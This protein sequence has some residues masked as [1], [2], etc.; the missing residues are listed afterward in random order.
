MG[1]VYAAD[2]L[3]LPRTVAIKVLRPAYRRNPEAVARLLAEAQAVNLI[4]HD[5]IVEIYDFVAD[6]SGPSYLVMELVAGE[7]LLDE[8]EREVC[9]PVRRVIDIGRQIADATRAVHDAGIVHRDLKPENVLLVAADE[10][11]VFVKLLDFGIAKVAEEGRAQSPL[12]ESLLPTTQHGMVVGTPD[13]MAPEQARGHAVDARADIFA[14]GVMLYEMLTGMRP[15]QGDSL[16]ELMTA[17]ECRTPIAPSYLRRDGDEIPPELET[18]VLRCLA[19][20]PD[21]RPASMHEVHRILQSLIEPPTPAPEPPLMQRALTH[22]AAMIAGAV[23]VLILTVGWGAHRHN[24]VREASA[25]EAPAVQPLAAAD[26]VR[27]TRERA[28]AA[29]ADARRN[30]V[31]VSKRPVIEARSTSSRRTQAKANPQAKA[32]VPATSRQPVA[33]RKHPPLRREVLKDAVLDPFSK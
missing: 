19:P 14:L 4:C 2:H 17:I 16:P 15:F 26:A 1:V 18:L 29:P 10:A 31:P 30:P 32:Q 28:L 7:P 23:A 6:P 9:L 25:L 3:M 5:H 27:A 21:E 33:K 8:L 20:E 12:P 22:R 11:P 13:Y 24:G